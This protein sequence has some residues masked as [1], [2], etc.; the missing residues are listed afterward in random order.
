MSFTVSFSFSGAQSATEKLIGI[1]CFADFA[2]FHKYLIHIYFESKYSDS[3]FSIRI[4]KNSNPQDSIFHYMHPYFIVCVL[5]LNKFLHVPIT[6]HLG[7]IAS[8]I[9]S[10][11]SSGSVSRSSQM[12]TASQKAMRHCNTKTVEATQGFCFKFREYFERQE[13]EDQS[14][15]ETA[16]NFYDQYNSEVPNL[17]WHRIYLYIFQS[18][19]IY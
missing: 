16:M 3:D 13:S 12:P 15:T 17:H 18:L 5:F 8:S 19:E 2:I 7:I 10:I 4:L 14:T 6:A 1:I 11:Q 9:S